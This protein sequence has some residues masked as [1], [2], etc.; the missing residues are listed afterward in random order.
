MS[1]QQLATIALLPVNYSQRVAKQNCNLKSRSTLFKNTPRV[2]VPSSSHDELD[3][4][5]ADFVLKKMRD[6]QKEYCKKLCQVT[7][8]TV[9][10]ET[11]KNNIED[12]NDSSKNW[13]S[14]E[15][16]FG[17]PDASKESRTQHPFKTVHEEY[18]ILNG[19]GLVGNV[20]GT[21]GLFTGFSFVAVANGAFAIWNR[22]LSK[23][24]KSAGRGLLAK[25]TVSRS[26]T[27]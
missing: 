14:I 1:E 26:S 25:R 27:T 20:G 15:Y 9:R 13:F 22:V 21:L 19:R 16:M 4:I 7:E 2:R 12:C 5:C 6:S 10:D 24:M 17:S 11:W 18:F 3:S 8:Y 23:I